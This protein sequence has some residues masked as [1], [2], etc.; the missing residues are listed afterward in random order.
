L[1]VEELREVQRQFGFLP[2]EQLAALSKRIDVPITRLH[3]VASFFPHFRLTPPPKADV[4]VCRD[5]SCHM[6]GADR[7]RTNLE[8]RFA[9]ARKEEVT[10]GGVSC[11]GQCDH[12]LACSIN[13]II[14][15]DLDETRVEEMILGVLSKGELPEPY[16]RFEKVECASDPYG[17]GQRYAAVR[18]LVESRGFNAALDALKASGLRGLGGAGF[19]T[20]V[21]WEGVRKEA[22]P[23]KYIVCNGDESEPG[24]FKDRFILTH[25]PH[26]TIEGMIVAGLITGAQKGVLYIRHEYE[27]QIE[28]CEEEI[29]RCR[30]EGI[31]GQRILGSDLNFEL[32]VFVSPG[33]Y[34][35][36][37][38]SAL[39]EA[40][41]GKRAEPRNKPPFPVSQGLWNKPTVINNVETF[42]H[43][44]QVLVRGVDWYKAQGVS[45]TAGLKFVGVSGDVMRPGVYELPMGT[46]M[47]DLIYKYAG[48]LPAGKKLKAIAPSGPSAGY[49]PASMVDVHLDFK[50]LADAGSMLGS[51]AVVVC[52]EPTCMLDMALSATQFFRN[53][54]CGKCVPCRVGSQ[55]MVEIL[56]GWTQGRGQESD[57]GLVNELSQALSLASICGL[58]QVVP[59]PIASVLKHFREEVE[60]HITRHECPSGIC[61]SGVATRPASTTVI[62]ARPA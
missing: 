61:F 52:A 45:G 14:Y 32:N 41:E 53:E 1:I 21:K 9:G 55:K 11:L 12:A 23:E 3:Q 49:L 35:C 19:P 25:I 34:I 51:G 47:S 13:D 59:A 22:D 60:A 36:G 54:S 28:I 57:L 24:T 39:L 20:A 15:G 17:S 29:R 10:I 2:A 33:G 48:G 30:K 42:A 38:E 8:R 27:Q 5:M 6:K 46:P 37:E 16:H 43:A 44:A 31:V 7:L 58:G 56:T 40:I 26:L 62:H 50:S 18:R 4:R